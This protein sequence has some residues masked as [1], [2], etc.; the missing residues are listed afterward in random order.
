[1]FWHPI[2]KTFCELGDALNV[3]FYLHNLGIV[4]SMLDRC[5]DSGK[6]V[7]NLFAA[8][9]CEV[10]FAVASP[11]SFECSVE[12]FGVIRGHYKDVTRRCSN[13]VDGVEYAGQC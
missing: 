3:I 2:S 11:S 7:D 13:S 12:E 10:D 4:F 5:V 1:M 6:D 8:C 9:K